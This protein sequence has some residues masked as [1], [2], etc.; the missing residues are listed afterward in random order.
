MRVVSRGWQ[1]LVL[2]VLVTALSCG[3]ITIDAALPADLANDRT[4]LMAA[5]G[6]GCHRVPEVGFAVCRRPLGDAVSDDFVAFFAPGTNCRRP[7]CTTIRIFQPSM[8]QVAELNFNKDGGRGVVRWS[9][10]IQSSR[11]ELEH[12]KYYPV[13][14]RTYFLNNQGAEEVVVTRGEIRLFVYIPQRTLTTPAGREV[15]LNYQPL[16][17]VPNA[18]VWA[19]EASHGHSRMKWSTA[20]RAYV[21][22]Y[23]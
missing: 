4:A 11:F 14:T 8:T 7:I 3:S 16:D 1:A 5:G 2:L 23:P 12:D 18:N 17:M 9:E 6:P 21:G 20:G 19:F 15:T 13:L 10:I 22:T